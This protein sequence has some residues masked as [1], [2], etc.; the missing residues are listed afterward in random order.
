MKVSIIIRALNEEKHLGKL[1]R[2]LAEQ[3]YRNFEVLLVSN[4]KL[5]LLQNEFNK[6]KFIKFISV[7]IK[8]PSYKRNIGSDKSKG[9]YLVFTDDDAYPSSDWL[10]KINQFINDNIDNKVIAGPTETPESDGYKAMLSSSFYES[11]IGGGNT[12]R[13]KPKKKINY[14]DDWPTVNF[15]IEKKLFNELGKF[16][17]KVWPGE[18]T[19]LCENIK[20]KNIKINYMPNLRVYHHRRDSFVKHFRQ[21]YNY[22]KT[23]GNLIANKLISITLKAIT[24]SI[25]FVYLMTIILN[26][27]LD[28][29]NM[30]THIPII[31]Y[32][33]LIFYESLKISFNKNIYVALL[34][35]IITVTSHITYGLAFLIGLFSKKLTILKRF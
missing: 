14:V 16:N 4:E 19:L 20:N 22:G 15:I 11:F 24:P 13:Y 2:G 25:F 7:D 35:P 1:F 21:V 6:F 10:E 30:Y 32:C 5:T 31:I 18:D 3:T 33:F 28:M 12:E 29:I 23:R 9:N 8:S 34:F 26:I 27:R 17:E